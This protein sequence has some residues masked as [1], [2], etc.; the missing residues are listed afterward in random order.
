MSKVV[1]VCVVTVAA[2]AFAVSA[3]VPAEAVSASGSAKATGRHVE[4]CPGV[5]ASYVVAAAAL[6]PLTAPFVMSATSEDAVR[7][8]C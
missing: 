8:A 2:A 7:S 3:A 5:V 4:W 6:S 1:R